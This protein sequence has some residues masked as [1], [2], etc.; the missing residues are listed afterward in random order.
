MGK[1]PDWGQS[2]YRIGKAGGKHTRGNKTGKPACLDSIVIVA[3]L[4]A[5]VAYAVDRL[6][7]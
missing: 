7:G 4:G 3:G 2:R 5:T 1:E 6:L